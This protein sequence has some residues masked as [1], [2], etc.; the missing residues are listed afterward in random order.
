[1]LEHFEL[2]LPAGVLAQTFHPQG[3]L[4]GQVS[5]TVSKPLKVQRIRLQLEAEETVAIRETRRGTPITLTTKEK[6]AFLLCGVLVFGSQEDLPS[7]QWETVPPGTHQFGFTLRFPAVNFPPSLNKPNGCR[8]SYTLRATLER[9]QKLQ[10]ALVF[11]DPVEV[12]VAPRYEAPSLQQ[13][14][15]QSETVEDPAAAL[16][17]RFTGTISL[18]TVCP[19]EISSAA[20]QVDSLCEVPMQTIQCELLEQVECFATV[21]GQTRTSM[22]ETVLRTYEADPSIADPPALTRRGHIH[23]PL[24]YELTPLSTRQMAI[25]YLLQFVI[26]FSTARGPAGIRKLYLTVPLTVVHRKTPQPASFP[27]YLEAGAV[28][29]FEMDLLPEFRPWDP[30]NP[31]WPKPAGQGSSSFD[32][33]QIPD[34]PT[35]PDTGRGNPG[36]LFKKWASMAS[37]P[38]PPKLPPRKPDNTPPLPP[39]ATTTNPVPTGSLRLP[40]FFGLGTSP[41]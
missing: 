10:N 38:A 32:P 25:R 37:I 3:Q 41:R 13:H 15:V 11:T 21:R 28:P 27:S 40:R 22:H 30:N 14:S 4:S 19:G 8:I 2:I 18:T 29:E 16:S 17:A 35:P 20:F 7:K 39:R 33:S 26:K 9:P 23:I 34:V 36:G 6:Q 5:L 24:P 31:F 12:R 1:M